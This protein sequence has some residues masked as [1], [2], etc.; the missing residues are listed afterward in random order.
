M[1]TTRKQFM[2][3][4]AMS[5]AAMFVGGFVGGCKDKPTEVPGETP[6]TNTAEQVKCFGINDCKGESACGVNKP[7]LGLES[8]CAGENEC[9]GKGWIKLSRTDCEAKSGEVLGT[10]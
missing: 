9:A 10:L 3:A 6:T 7:E 2:S 4:F 5:A 8:A 1:T